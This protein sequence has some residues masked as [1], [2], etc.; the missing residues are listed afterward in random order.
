LFVALVACAAFAV[1]NTTMPSY[2]AVGKTPR[3]LGRSIG[4]QQKDA[5]QQLIQADKSLIEVLQPWMAANKSDYDAFV[6]INKKT[7]PDIFEEICGI[8]EGAGLNESDVILLMLRPE[9]EALVQ[10]HPA[11]DNCFDIICNAEHHNAFVAH[12]EDWTPAYKP[13]GFVL[14]EDMAFADTK[15]NAM[16]ITAFTYPASPVGFTFGYNSEGLVT[17]C[18]GLNPIP[19]KVGKLGRY[20]INRDVLAAKTVDDALDRLKKAA[21]YSALGFGMS[22]GRVGSHRLYHAEMAPY[23]PHDPKGVDSDGHVDIIKIERGETYLHSNSY[24]HP[25]FKGYITQYTSNSTFARLARAA[26]MAEPITRD[27][28]LQILGD[29]NN[30]KYPIYRY[31]DPNDPEEL[32]TISTALMDLDDALVYVYGGNP[33][34]YAPVVVMPLYNPDNGE[35]KTWF[36]AFLIT[37]IGGGVLLLAVIFLACFLCCCCCCQCCN[38]GQRGSVNSAYRRVGP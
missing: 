4:E 2:Y 36:T 26:Q 29:E 28:A 6:A 33:K 11:N 8:A 15:V 9:I 38:A 20:F 24:T 5:F 35:A 12:N 25:Y 3:E 32:A 14:H 18:N 10:P 37:A 34:T 30:T 21:P 13:F 16:H 23:D 19:C 27:L 22:I 1:T 17:S 7:Y 31:G